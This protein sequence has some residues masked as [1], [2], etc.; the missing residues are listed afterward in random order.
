MT[1]PPLDK[2]MCSHVQRTANRWKAGSRFFRHRLM[3]MVVLLIWTSGGVF[4]QAQ[5]RPPLT[6]AARSSWFMYFG[7]HPASENWFIHLEGQYRREGFGQRW[8]QLLLRPGV[9]RKTGERMSTLA[10]YTY[11]RGYPLEGSSLSDPA[12]TGPQPEHRVLE[13]FTIRHPLVGQGERAVSLSHRLRAEQRFQGTAIAGRGVARWKFAQRARYRLTADIP[14]GWSTGGARPDYASIYNEIFFNVRLKSGDG[15]LNQNRTYGALGWNLSEQWQLE[16]GYL[17][18]YTPRPT[19]IVDTH[20][21]A[22]QVTVNST[23]PLRKLLR[24]GK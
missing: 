6:G 23:A 13:E 18:Q 10:A 15:L 7:D 4:S 5:Q 22:L 8:E 14:F 16:L 3:G 24:M 9:G 20:N 12:A 11:L 1:P 19:G 2:S 21:Q 17:H